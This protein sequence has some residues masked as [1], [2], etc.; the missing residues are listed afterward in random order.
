M[1]TSAHSR[2][3]VA[4]SNA[5]SGSF[6][7]SSSAPPSHR[8]ITIHPRSETTPC[9][10]RI[11]GWFR[12]H[13]IVASRRIIFAMFWG[14]TTSFASPNSAFTATDLP[15]YDALYTAPYPPE[16]RMSAALREIFDAGISGVMSI[17]RGSFCFARNASKVSFTPSIFCDT[18]LTT[19]FISVTS[20]FTSLTSPLRSG[21][22]LS[23]NPRRPHRR[24]V[25]RS[26]GLKHAYM[27]PNVVD[28]PRNTTTA[29]TMPT[30]DPEPD[31]EE[32]EEPRTGGGGDGLSVGGGGGGG[33]GGAGS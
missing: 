20:L 10:L 14:T 13:M 27:I 11:F 17:R 5:S 16:P 22:I 24:S 30:T 2:V 33:G 12:L 1:A 9:T 8:S 21:T 19:L 25:R 4:S 23:A 7:A 15:P 28:G 31:E 26:A 18:V 3:C 29:T 6:S 32:E